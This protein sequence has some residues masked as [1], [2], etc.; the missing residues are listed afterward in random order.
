M[1][2]SG[3][4]DHGPMLAISPRAPPGSPTKAGLSYV[5]DVRSDVC[6]RLAGG[7]QGVVGLKAGDRVKHPH[8]DIVVDGEEALVAQVIETDLTSTF[9]TVSTFLPDMLA[10]HAGVIIM[11]ASAA[12]RQAAKSSAAYA[13]AK[14]SVVAFS[15]HLAGALAS[16]R[17][18]RPP[19]SSLRHRPHRGS[20][21]SRLIS[22]AARSCCEKHHQPACIRFREGTA[23]SVRR[24]RNRWPSRPHPARS[25]RDAAPPDSHSSGRACLTCPLT[26][27]NWNY[28]HCADL[29]HLAAWPRSS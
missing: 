9:L 19:H 21:V 2:R 1:S 12:G 8:G 22:P 17:T 26:P 14:A 5:E 27:A 3:S 23:P 24:S 28:R 4:D 16:P 29:S 25:A 13:A 6:E 7:C 10:R 20:P 15:R 18:S 11:M